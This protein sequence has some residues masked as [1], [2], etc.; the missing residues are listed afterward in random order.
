M[1]V[2]LTEK[3]FSRLREFVK[4][5][6]GKEIVFMSNDNDLNRKVAEKLP[7][8]I[9]IIPLEERR[10][11][12]KQRDSGMN[13]IITKIFKKNKISLGFD[14]N[15]LINSKYKERILSRL[16]QNVKLCSRLKVQIKF[17]YNEK[18]FNLVDLKAL[19][20]V[21][22]MPTWMTRNL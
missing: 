1:R 9:I 8:Q 11:Y 16:R 14:V 13:E 19:G 15:E 2:I 17:I 22:G 10:D 18:S 3:N 7:I 6:K 12:T 20:F 4:K 21:V 5:E